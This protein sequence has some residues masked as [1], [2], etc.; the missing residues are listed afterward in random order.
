MG[1][2]FFAPLSEQKTELP[3]IVIVTMQ[4]V[5]TIP[6]KQRTRTL[7]DGE[8]AECSD[9]QYRDDG[10]HWKKHTRSTTSLVYSTCHNNSQCS[11]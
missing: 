1:E 6:E 3:Y 11:F 5:Y 9:E 7:V 10:D 8:V 4:S 2:R